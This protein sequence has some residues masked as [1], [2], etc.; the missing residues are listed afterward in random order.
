MDKMKKLLGKDVIIELK[1]DVYIGTVTF[2]ND[3][4]I[5]IQAM[6][7]KTS[8]V[9]ATKFYKNEMLSIKPLK[10]QH[11]VDTDDCTDFTLQELT[12]MSLTLSSYLLIER[13]DSVYH[14]AIDEIESESF[15]GF[16][17]PG[18]DGGRFSD[19]SIVAISTSKTVF[20][21][22]VQVMGRIENKIKNILEANAPKKIVHD[23]SRAADHLEHK[24]NINLSGVFDSMVNVTMDFNRSRE[25]F[26][27]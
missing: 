4:Y 8:A 23:A 19:S 3:K 10:A 16:Y 1:G 21:F 22:D 7:F 9:V 26:F 24:H 20:L 6:E 14:N 2:S 25:K 18:I 27:R 12:R 13:F 11:H 15:I 17:M 5:N